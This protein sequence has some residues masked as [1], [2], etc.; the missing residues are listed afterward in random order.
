MPKQ[1]TNR[2]YKR[3]EAHRDARLFIIVT[4]GE[5]EDKYFG[6]FDKKNQRIRVQMVPRDGQASAPKHFLE[7]LNKYL[8]NADTQPQSSD[9]IWFVLDVDTWTRASIDE[10]IVLCEQT[11]N[12]HIAISNPCF[13]VW[14]N[15]HT[16]ALP[17]DAEDCEALKTL[18]GARIRGGFHPN[19]VCPLIDAAI[20]NA[21]G[22]DSHPAQDFPDRM[23]TK[24]YWLAEAMLEVLGRHWR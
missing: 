19:T 16:G 22:A 14:L 6:W 4:E 23:Q 2:S 8:D 3:G 21:R 18:L 7:R 13:E 20:Q 17:A 10:L 1:N 5:R 15:L 12:W 11:P 24:V 9:S